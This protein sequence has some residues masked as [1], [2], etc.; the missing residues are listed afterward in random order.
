MS[1][2][3][4]TRWLKPKECL[5]GSQEWRSITHAA[6][7]GAEIHAKP[8]L[9]G[10]I[11]FVHGVNSE[12]EWYEDAERELCKGL[13][14]RLNLTNTSY[15]LKEN[16]YYKPRFILDEKNYDNSHYIYEEPIRTLTELGNSPV[17][18]FYWGYCAT[19]EDLG[20]YILYSIKK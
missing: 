11:I 1:N 15:I 10:I 12:G 3:K 2:S 14:E 16:I 8:H 4:P 6:N 9:P 19:D 17:I 7:I 18:R 20:Q 5:D 13:N